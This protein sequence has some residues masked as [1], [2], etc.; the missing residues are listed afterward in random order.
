MNDKMKAACAHLHV[1]YR[2][3]SIGVGGTR[4]GWECDNGCG[5]PFGPI[6]LAR[7][8]GDVKKVITKKCSAPERHFDAEVADAY[9]AIWRWPR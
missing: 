2:T 1:S 4:G 6:P 7:D 8:Q 5:Q 3:E 9:H